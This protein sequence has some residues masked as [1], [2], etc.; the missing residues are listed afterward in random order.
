MAKVLITLL[1]GIAL[2]L[3]A[4]EFG[5]DLGQH[6]CSIDVTAEGNGRQM[7]RRIPSDMDITLKCYRPSAQWYYRDKYQLKGY[8]IQLERA[9]PGQ[10]GIYSCQDGQNRWYNISLTVGHQE[11]TGTN[12]IASF[13]AVDSS[14]ADVEFQLL[15]S[16]QKSL[17]L[18]K[19]LP[20]TAQ[21]TAGTLLHLNCSPTD[22]DGHRVNITWLHNNTH[23]L[24]GRG[25]IKTNG[26]TL[27]VGQLQP[28]DAGSYRCRLCAEQGCV[29]STETQ[30]EVVT[31][32]H[33]APVLRPGY[34]HNI[35][36][37][38]EEHVKFLCPL[39][40]STLE[41]KI[42]WLHKEY[43]DN[44]D[45]VL[46]D[47][48][49]NPTIPKDF[50]PMITLKDE[51]QVL[52]LGNVIMEDAGWYICIAENQLGRTAGA[53]YL[54]LRQSVDTTTTARIPAAS[55]GTTTAATP[56]KADADEDAYEEE[57]GDVIPDK[58][59]PV[60][61]KELQRL[62]HKVAGKTIT[63]AC[64]VDQTANITWTKNK[65]QLN[66]PHGKY[67]QKKWILR[68]EDATTEDSGTY[69]CLVC[70]SFGCIDF[71]FSVKIFE[72]TRS[73]PI[74]VVP[75]N[76]TV[77]VNN[78]VAME[79]S[80]LSDL[81]PNVH[82]MRVKPR[83]MSH[84]LDDLQ[85][86]ELNT[87]EVSNPSMLKL[88]NVTHEDEGWYTCVASNSLGHSNSSVYLRVV[89]YMPHLEVYALLRAH[90]LGFMVAGISI[91]VLFLSGSAFTVYMLRRLR[92]EKLL[93]HRIETVHQWTKKV[94]I[95]RPTSEDQGSACCAG[96]LQIPVIRIEKQRTTFST[97]ESGA[98]PAQGF[99]EYEFPLDSNWEIPRQ[100]LRLGSILG[101][102]AFGRVVM[103]EAEGLPRSPHPTETIVAVKMVKEEHTDADMASLVREMEVMK[104]IGK[105][106]NI[107]NLLGCC[108]QGGP[109]WVIVEYAPHGNLKDFLKQNRPG[110]PQRRSDSDGYLDDKPL[111]PSQQLGEKELTKF[112]FQI[113]RGMEYLASRRVGSHS[114]LSRKVYT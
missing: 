16:T 108:S 79:C 80:V 44:I 104:M 113:A 84:H 4:P 81:Q 51:P 11:T 66:R 93:K 103:A 75:H 96:D 14:E 50:Q 67:I 18:L 41:P 40:D 77:L 37:V 12:D 49:A 25:R 9:R 36:T 85:V 56:A 47:L 53:A 24:G 99:N 78:S 22:A 112:A 57:P 34:P 52:A 72:R 42:T 54:E 106:I 71:S 89:D 59:P 74:I 64:P 87:T 70:N 58:G 8:T 29:L 20:P 55:K 1:S 30:L 45:A 28:E 2:V 90:P 3:A 6:R 105:H 91:V 109:L 10:S 68:F 46:Q 63:L 110:A 88:H 21:R 94:I 33:A 5:C 7:V 31:R 114:D 43:V 111:L 39:E 27:T 92:R 97:T 73:S 101:E 13:A 98:D 32:S 23:I 65:K 82:W 15:N 107:I 60:F 19:P 17:E 48:K 86:I 83:N 35:T 95:Y 76:Q 61:K 26:W 38:I 69:T 102:G 100:Q 62:E